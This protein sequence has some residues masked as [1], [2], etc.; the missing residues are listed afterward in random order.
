VD[1]LDIS[2]LS[3]GGVDPC[4][5]LGLKEGK[6]TPRERFLTHTPDSELY[7]TVDGGKTSS[8]RQA[9]S[10]PAPNRPFKFQKRS[11]FFIRLQHETLSVLA[12]CIGN[13]DRVAVR[14]QS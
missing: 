12:V 4:G 14:V 7:I 6:K 3:L 13:P 10:P 5:L 1:S 9:Q 8:A 11:Q 2:F